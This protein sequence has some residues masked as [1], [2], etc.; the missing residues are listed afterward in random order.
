MGG[1]GGGGRAHVTGT[2]CQGHCV[3]QTRKKMGVEIN[4][5][6]ER[7]YVPQSRP[8]HRGYSSKPQAHQPIDP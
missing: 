3:Q 5:C 8:G 6:D 1:A 4:E 2:K 7:E